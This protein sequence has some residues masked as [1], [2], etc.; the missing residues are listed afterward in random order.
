MYLL[1]IHN[2]LYMYI[3][4]MM[5]SYLTFKRYIHMYY[6]KKIHHTVYKMEFLILCHEQKS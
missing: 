6:I 3:H 1:Y 4:F 2:S 5:Q